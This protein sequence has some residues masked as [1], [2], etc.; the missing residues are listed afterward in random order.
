M[1]K[2][3]CSILLS[4]FLLFPF[5]VL[6]EG[7]ISVSPSSLTIEQGSSKTF[8]ITAYNA[9]GDVSVRTN[10]NG[11]ASVS[12]GSWGTGMV[13]EKETKSGTVTVTGNSVGTTTITLTIDGATFDGDD[14]AGQTKTITVNVVA[15]Q[16]P[17]GGNGGGNNNPTP[18]P[19]PNQTPVVTDN[20]SS[21]TNLSS[22]KV[23]GNNIS[24][25]DGIYALEVSN[26][27][28]NVE[29]EATAE[30]SKAKV[31]GNGKKD[32]SVGENVFDIVVTAENGASTTHKLIVTRKEYNVLKDLDEVLKQDKDIEIRIFENDKLSKS[33][34]DKIRDSKKKV[35]LEFI[36]SDKVLY[37]WVLDGKNIKGVNSFNPIIG[38]K[39]DNNDVMEEALNYPDGIYL[40]FIDCG[41][42]PKGALLKYFV[43]DKY[44]DKDK[45]NLYTY[46]EKSK[47]VV[48][49]EKDIVVKD[50][51][52]ELKI[53]DAVKHVMTQANILSEESSSFNIWIII[54]IILF[55]MVLL[56]GVFTF[57]TK[58]KT[59]V[60]KHTSEV[61]VTDNAVP[62]ITEVFTDKEENSSV[63]TL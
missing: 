46:D 8:T 19:R 43:G 18:A 16:A 32:I 44:S 14:L 17:S 29:I 41:D 38:S 9:I 1:K 13:G 2:I 10:N 31:T 20:R 51:Y 27:V 30:D 28:S 47:K 60:V 45:I 48:E 6:A 15:K 57:I 36:S 33:D 61:S 22:L 49:L 12:T 37:T 58:K 39:I 59:V 35:A 11:V 50:G 4:L 56:L 55:I 53:S 26:F 42:I 63:E 23:N 24:V 21:N 62:V 7:Y 5:G 54:S 40:S 25:K 34:L 3:L 52:V